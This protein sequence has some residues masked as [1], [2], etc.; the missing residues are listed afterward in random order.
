MG[1]TKSTYPRIFELN[2]ETYT[3]GCGHWLNVRIGDRLYAD[4]W[5]GVN[6]ENKAVFRGS[7]FTSLPLDKAKKILRNMLIKKNYDTSFIE[8]IMRVCIADKEERGKFSSPTLSPCLTP[9]T[10]FSDLGQV[11]IDDIQINQK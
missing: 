3:P 10:S 7:G 8:G 6:E 1:N 11:D 9:Q 4:M 2:P 5:I